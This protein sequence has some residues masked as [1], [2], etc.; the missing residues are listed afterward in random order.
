MD[1]I[2]A[3]GVGLALRAIIDT[4]T[5]HNHRVNGSLVGLWE[6][7]VLHHFLAKFPRSLDPFVAFGFR[8]FVDLL[9]TASVTRLAIVVV[10]TG[11]GLLLSDLGLELLEDKR[12]R[13]LWRR[14]QRALPAFLRPYTTARAPSRVQFLQVPPN[15]STTSS[16][17]ARSPPILR[18]PISPRSQPQLRPHARS[19]VPPVPARRPSTR[20]LP[21]S[22][23]DWS[24]ADTEATRASRL[25]QLPMRTRTPSE[26]DYIP[27]IPH[28]PGMETYPSIIRPASRPVSRPTRSVAS[29]LTTPEQSG[30]QASG[31]DGRPRDYSGLTTPLERSI[32]PE[33]RRERLPPVMIIEDDGFHDGARTPTRT[34]LTDSPPIPIPLRPSSRHLDPLVSVP[35]ELGDPLPTPSIAPPAGEMP[36]IPTPDDVDAAMTERGTGNRSPP[37]SY[38]QMDTKFPDNVSV[39]ESQ[40]PSVISEHSH[41]ALVSRADTLR[42][43]AVELDATRAKL[44]REYDA[45]NR[46][47]DFWLAFRLKVEHDRAAQNAQAMHARAERRYFKAHNRT[48]EPQTIDVH[49]LKVPEAVARVEQSL[50]DAL[51]AGTPELR[52]IT[53]RGNHSKGKI[54]VLKLAIIGAMEE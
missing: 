35:P 36:D 40:A 23:S 21:G 11:L 46:D 26:L 49:R 32:S 17:T 18:S 16:N 39:A 48:P 37:P 31:S 50:F 27:D 38:D 7:A 15:A 5:H 51:E 20:P 9:F 52:V 30:S 10:W 45:A 2:F 41:G 29:G 6:G 28:T 3:I 8:L 42:K 33:T 4:V 47:K 19:P 34:E 43:E 12:F 44:K 24:E 53:G 54:P 13:R 25:Q 1:N 22:F 14:V